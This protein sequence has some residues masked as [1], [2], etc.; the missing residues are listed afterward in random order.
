MCSDRP[1]LTQGWDFCNNTRAPSCSC[2]SKRF[3]AIGLAV[4]TGSTQL[5]ASA[6]RETHVQSVHCQYCEKDWSTWVGS[7]GQW[8]QLHAIMN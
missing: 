1:V 6:Y 5:H 2:R 3:E 8:H 7:D 4:I